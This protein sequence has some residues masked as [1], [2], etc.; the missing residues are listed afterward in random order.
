MSVDDL[1]L[2]GSAKFLPDSEFIS[3][4]F[5]SVVRKRSSF[6]HTG[7]EITTEVFTHTSMEITM[8]VFPSGSK[9]ACISQTT[10]FN[11]MVL[12]SSTCTFTEFRSLREKLFWLTHTRRDISGATA[13]LGKIT[14]EEFGLNP[15]HCRFLA[16][17]IV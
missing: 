7:M 4:R 10:Y 8:E 6:T 15:L 9:L 13:E 3:R 14:E 11:N 1:R 2:T 12:L 5:E 16:N 17:S